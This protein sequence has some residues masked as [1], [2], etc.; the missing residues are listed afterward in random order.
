MKK[1]ISNTEK[2]VEEFL[3][4]AS[5]LKGE[6]KPI[7]VLKA[8][9]YQISK[10]NVL[11]RA[12]SDGN[13]RYFYGINYITIEEMANLLNPYIAFICGS[14]GKVI[15]LPA[16]LLFDNLHKISHD[17]NGEYKINIDKELNIV[18]R[19]RGNR[20]D[21]TEYV[22][23]W[24]ILLSPIKQDIGGIETVEESMHSILEGRLLEIGNYRGYNTYCSDKSKKF[25]AKLLSDISSLGKCPELQ[26]SDY[27][28]LRKIDV[29][30]FKEK[31]NN[32][33][34][35]KAFEIELSTGTWPGVGRMA[36]LTDYSNVN[37]YIISNDL[38][39]Y[40]KVIRTFPVFKQRF[41]HIKTDL[42]GDLYSAEKNILELRYNIG[43]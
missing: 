19:G 28:L 5:N 34:P 6:I 33:I 22:N 41:T 43:L 20:L 38:K 7:K 24:N 30:W 1:A 14:I 35:E 25:N 4:K 32:L 2:L 37:F 13:R 29:L 39:K 12:A 21:C 16:Q 10:A 9:V 23:N 36:T 26:F 40:N 17:R 27:D 11:V 42:I 15:I 3:Q 8:R 18:L 31:R